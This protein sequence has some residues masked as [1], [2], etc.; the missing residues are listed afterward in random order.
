MLRFREKGL[1]Q[2][3]RRVTSAR[4]SDGLSS[5]PSAHCVCPWQ[6]NIVAGVGELMRT[7]ERLSKQE[8]AA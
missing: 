6:P 7:A 4:L 1:N 8:G 3:D 5:A 2:Q